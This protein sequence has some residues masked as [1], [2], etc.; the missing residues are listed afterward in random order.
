MYSYMPKKYVRD[1]TWD[2]GKSFLF[3]DHRRKAKKLGINIHELFYILNR[4]NYKRVRKYFYPQL[5]KL[6][7]CNHINLVKLK[8]SLA[9]HIFYKKQL[10]ITKQ[11]KL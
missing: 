9:E 11:N 5:T 6:C 1:I 8:G 4:S 2:N 10:E 7:Q 3:R